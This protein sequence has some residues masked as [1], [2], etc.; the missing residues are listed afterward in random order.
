MYELVSEVLC[1]NVEE[2]TYESF[3]GIKYIPLIYNSTSRMTSQDRTLHTVISIAHICMYCLLQLLCKQTKYEY[4][5]VPKGKFPNVTSKMI[6]ANE[7][8]H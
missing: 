5:E 1:P 7:P 3:A 8:K 6:R 2:M 4:R